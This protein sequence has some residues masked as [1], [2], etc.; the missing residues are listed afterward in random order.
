MSKAENASIS[1]ERAPTQKQRK[2]LVSHLSQ[3]IENQRRELVFIIAQQPLMDRFMGLVGMVGMLK[4]N[5]DLS[6]LEQAHL[7]KMIAVEYSMLP[8]KSHVHGLKEFLS[9]V[10]AHAGPEIAR[11]EALDV[12]G[13]LPK[14]W[15]AAHA[16]VLKVDSTYLPDQPKP[17]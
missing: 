4:G 15:N 11:N 6:D 8:K 3:L 16:D 7:R 13:N 12:G 14:T 1:T 9:E 5:N 2:E 10:E 17:E